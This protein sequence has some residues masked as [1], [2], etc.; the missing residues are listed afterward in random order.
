LKTET[1][2]AYQERSWTWWMKIMTSIAEE[3]I[4]K[5]QDAGGIVALGTDQTIGPAV[6]RE[7]E[8]LVDAGIAPL[9][10][11]TIATHNA[12]LFLGK[13]KQ[14]GLVAPGMKADLVL[15]EA[16]PAKDI[17]NAKRISAV[18]KNGAMIDLAKLDLAA[19]R[20]P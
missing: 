5:I 9:D 20:A 15:L 16:D 17:N 8:L 18:I 13:E 4:R 6:H 10:V 19:V 3:N 12:A 14:L 2:K 1:R 7:M 11:I